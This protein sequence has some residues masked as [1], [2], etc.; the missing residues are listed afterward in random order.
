MNTK[1]QSSFEKI[2][3][4]GIRFLVLKKVGDCYCKKTDGDLF[5]ILPDPLCKNCNGTGY[6][7][8]K[9]LTEKLRFQYVELKTSSDFATVYFPE[10]F[11]INYEDLVVFLKVDS[12]N[13]LIEPMKVDV[14]CKIVSIMPSIVDDFSFKELTLKKLHYIPFDEVVD[15]NG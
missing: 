12:S 11:K 9:V 10:N 7:R 14:Y 4:T 6:A 15:L 2:S 8:K 3:K 5:E 1:I 13:E